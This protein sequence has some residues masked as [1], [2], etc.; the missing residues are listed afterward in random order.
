MKSTLSVIMVLLCVCGKSQLV[1]DESYLDESFWH[2]K[3]K[4]EYT[5]LKKDT[6]LLKDL[7]AE[8]IYESHDGCSGCSIDEFMKMCFNGPESSKWSWS[9]MNSILRYGFEIIPADTSRF[10]I[11]DSIAFR[12][13]S[14]LSKIN[15]DEEL[16]V[17]GQ[18]VNIRDKPGI[19][20]KIIRMS[21]F[22]KFDC[23]C[24]ISSATDEDYQDL[25][26]I[27]WVQIRRGGKVIGYVATKYTSFDINREIIVGKENGKWKIFSF[28]YTRFC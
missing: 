26:G 15:N 19:K 28:N 9:E 20:S 7:L 16:I 18:N 11:N 14:Y 10:Q 23:T 27:Q 5:V 24:N 25:D 8:T 2:F 21:S 17:L 6:V 22:E 3:T 13:P 12:A 1:H 4:L